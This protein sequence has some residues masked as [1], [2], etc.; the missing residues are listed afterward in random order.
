MGACVVNTALWKHQVEALEVL[1]KSVGQGVRRIVLSA[2]TGSGKTL[3]AAA[4]VDGAICKG[5]RMAFVVPSISL[6]DQ[7]VEKLYEEGIR[8]VG[9]IQANHSMTDWSKPVQVCSVQTLAKRGAFPEAKVVVIDEV[10][11]LHDLHKKWLAHQD[12]QSVPF[13]G[14][15]ATPWTKG[16]G[17][18]FQT[19]LVAATTQEL[20][21]KGH[22]SKFTV[23][24][25]PKADISKVKVVAGDYQQDQL[26]GAMRAG[27]LTA[28]I[29]KTWQD[30]WGK[31]KTLVFAVNRAHAE[32]LHARFEEAGVKSAY[33]DGETCGG[34]R[35]DIK[36]GFHNGTYQVVCNI[37]TLTTG[38]DWDVRCLVLARPTKSEMLFVQIIGRA[39]RT[40]DGKDKA[41]IL[42]HSETS[43][44]MM[45]K[46]G[47]LATIGYDHLDDGKPRPKADATERKK[48]LP[49]PCPSCASV[50]P[51]LARVCTECGHTLPLAS[52]VTERNGMLVELTPE[53]VH[54]IAK[55]RRREYTYAEK[56]QWLA[57]LKGYAEE[58]SKSDKWVLANYRQKFAMWPPRSAV[59]TVQAME[60]SFEITQYIRS[61]MIAWAKSR[62]KAA[63]MVAAE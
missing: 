48:P 14:L 43:Q 58:H 12:W 50:Q 1:R 17:K 18:H 57:E 31:D 23:F 54:L 40:A 30:R 59:D 3:L 34:D 20:I 42:D 25:C 35:D 52:G 37:G 15:S 51:R 41:I 4:I 29:V 56:M 62:E 45:R 16:L 2:P 19:L 26:S 22:L 63:R 49:K 24:A 27:T 38:V 53:T 10:H 46:F 9:V 55:G 60:P 61:R 6:I 47:S 32:V 33:Q 36:R 39:L 5:N 21:D 11:A 44:E 8:D 7:T 28:D 13:I